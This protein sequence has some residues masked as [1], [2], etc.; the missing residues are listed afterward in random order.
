MSTVNSNPNSTVEDTVFQELSKEASKQL[1]D[2]EELLGAFPPPVE[3]ENCSYSVI[4]SMGDPE[5]NTGAL[6]RAALALSASGIPLRIRLCGTGNGSANFIVGTTPD[7]TQTL[8]H[9]LKSTL[10]VIKTE[11]VALQEESF[12][13]DS[14]AVCGNVCSAEPDRTPSARMDDIIRLLCSGRCRVGMDFFPL[15]SGDA[16]IAEHYSSLAEVHDRLRECSEMTAQVTRNATTGVSTVTA[17]KLFSQNRPDTFGIGPTTIKRNTPARQGAALA[18]AELERLQKILRS[19]GWMVSLRVQAEQAELLAALQAILGSNILS[20]GMSCRWISPYENRISLLLPQQDLPVLLSFPAEPFPGLQMQSIR[21]YGM[22]PPVSADGEGAEIG[23]LVWQGEVTETPFKISARQLTRHAG[24]FGISGTGKANAIHALLRGLDDTPFLIIDPGTQG[25]RWLA[26][27][28]KNAEFCTMRA[29]SARR[30][31]INPFWFPAGSSLQY[32]IHILTELIGSTL[33]GDDVACGI[34]EQ[35]ISQT[36]ADMGWN[37]ATNRNYYE[38]LLETDKLYPTFSHLCE[39]VISYF[40]HIA[41][42]SSVQTCKHAILVRLRSFTTGACGILLN[43]SVPTPL[44]DWIKERKTVVIEL[45]ALGS[46]PMKAVAAGALLAQYFQYIRACYPPGGAALHRLLVLDDA[47]RLFAPQYGQTQLLG[48]M[49]TQ[50]PDYAVGCLVAAQSPVDLSSD[51]LKNLDGRI[52]FRSVRQEDVS[53]LQNDL[54]L[55]AQDHTLHTL[56]DGQAL[57]RFSTMESPACVR[58]HRQPET[59]LPVQLPD[60]S[61]DPAEELA[62][63]LLDTSSQLQEIV[64]LLM[65]PLYHQIL[66]D[67]DRRS[68]S[69]ALSQKLYSVIQDALAHHTLVDMIGDTDTDDLIVQLITIVFG[70]FVRSRYQLGYCLQSMIEMYASRILHLTIGGETIREADWRALLDYRR[71]LLDQRF[72][73]MLKRSRGVTLSLIRERFGLTPHFELIASVLSDAYNTD[74]IDLSEEELFV[75]LQPILRAS[76]LEVPDKSRIRAELLHAVYV[77]LH[78]EED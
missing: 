27:E 32:H 36:Y 56:P 9:I 33:Q 62:A 11:N 61:I 68:L 17:P 73:E 49:L 13:L 41:H 19:G 57:V 55:D 46:D 16:W 14:S 10:R 47:H 44:E 18:E 64:N 76:F 37:L 12:A 38:Q 35:C 58:I 31:Q 59:A 67:E 74:W 5:G 34:L 23:N 60:D 75:S 54:L 66:F 71:S 51:V 21:S 70:E 20:L 43:H 53:S 39:T 6:L 1:A 45:D 8:H 30:L 77:C 29:D 15:N 48:D 65:E 26:N 25:Y 78:D 3:D 40:D 50:L 7:S 4:R 72:V 22:N 52:V 2:L 28:N 69:N 42:E 63:H 24:I